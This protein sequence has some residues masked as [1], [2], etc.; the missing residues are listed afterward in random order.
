MN[1]IYLAVMVLMLFYFGLQVIT[2]A[3][4]PTASDWR[5]ISAI[6]VGVL[7]LPMLLF[8]FIA[9]GRYSITTIVPATNTRVGNILVIQADGYK[10]II[11]DRI[12]L[13]D[14]PVQIKMVQDL[15]AW[16]F[17]ISDGLTISVELAPT[18]E[19]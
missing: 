1:E 15:N 6:I 14:K 10:P 17:A 8:S 11:E 12:E 7:F 9:F 16:G 13:I 2:N 19:K 5:P 3:F 18:P 4:G